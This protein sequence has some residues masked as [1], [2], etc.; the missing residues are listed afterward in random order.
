[1]AL[2]G[3]QREA[4]KILGAAAWP[5]FRR[6]TGYWFAQDALRQLP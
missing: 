5:L 1:M 4:A 2:Q 6:K 3:L